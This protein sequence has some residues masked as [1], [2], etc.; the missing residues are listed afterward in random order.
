MTR[1]MTLAACAALAL[2]TSGCAQLA[3][4]NTGL[5]PELKPLELR[6]KTD[7]SCGALAR[8]VAG[9][10]DQKLTADQ[11]LAVVEYCEDRDRA[12]ALT[13]DPNAARKVLQGALAQAP[14]K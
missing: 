6:V 11:A 12:M 14:V 8:E 3:A 13:I 4:F 5:V 9:V 7:K 1:F 2:T 10:G